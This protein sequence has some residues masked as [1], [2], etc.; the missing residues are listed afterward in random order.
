MHLHYPA[1]FKFQSIIYIIKN[2][3][4]NKIEIVSAK[5][6][7]ERYAAQQALTA[8][9]RHQASYRG[10]IAAELDF[11]EDEYDKSSKLY[12]GIVGKHAVYFEFISDEDGMIAEFDRFTFD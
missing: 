12:F 4:Y 10:R 9:L 6:D 8:S 3:K 1:C 2:I 7:A 11:D 5:A